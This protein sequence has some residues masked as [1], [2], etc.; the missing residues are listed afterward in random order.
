MVSLIEVLYPYV[1]Q[2]LVIE[3]FLKPKYGHSIFSFFLL[4]HKTHQFLP[5]SIK[6]SPNSFSWSSSSVTTVFEL[7]SKTFQFSGHN[8]LPMA[9]RNVHTFTTISPYLAMF[10]LRWGVTLFLKPSLPRLDLHSIVCFNIHPLW[11][12]FGCCLVL[13][14][15]WEDLRLFLCPRA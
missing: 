15:L 7:H 11:L 10:V 2:L 13:Y 6:Q 1:A 8:M 4:L 3:N 9:C 14:I 12:I 5:L